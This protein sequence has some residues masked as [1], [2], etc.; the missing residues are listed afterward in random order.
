MKMQRQIRL[1]RKAYR[2]LRA[3]PESEASY[4][5][6]HPYRRGEQRE[7]TAFEA[8]DLQE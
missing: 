6:K 1:Q 7:W 4:K 8:A 2:K 5:P 3:L